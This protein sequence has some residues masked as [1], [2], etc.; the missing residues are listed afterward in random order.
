V[1]EGNATAVAAVIAAVVSIITLVVS[2][3]AASRSEIRAA[4]RQVLAP[5]LETLSEN[6]YTIIAGVV[7]MRK[8]SLAD[9]DV[10]EW[11]TRAKGAGKQ[12]DATRRKV[13]YFLPGLEEG[14]RQLVVASDH[15][16]TIASI[17]GDYADKLI[18][19]YQRLS[20]QIDAAVR[21]S[22]RRVCL[23]EST[24]DGG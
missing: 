15:V 1:T 14:L 8:R 4:H 13:R 7:V 3:L 17:P 5:Y 24:D 2:S 9:Q 10:R 6:L 22:Y 12:V 21:R 23:R 20:R 18:T 16:A 11:Q 19:A